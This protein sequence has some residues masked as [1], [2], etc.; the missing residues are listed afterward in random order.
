MDTNEQI[1]VKLVG[2]SCLGAPDSITVVQNFEDENVD[3]TVRYIS[4]FSYFPLR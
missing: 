2:L 4:Q 3:K 1:R